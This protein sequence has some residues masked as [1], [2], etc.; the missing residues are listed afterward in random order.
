MKK[1]FFS[2][3]ACVAFAGSAFASNEVVENNMEIEDSVTS[4]DKVEF[5][6]TCL[7]NIYNSRGEFLDTVAVTNV[8]DNVSCSSQSVS[9]SAIYH[10]RQDHY[11]LLPSH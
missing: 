4:T 5:A 9:D 1:V 11:V 10:Y 2:A 8:P 7:V 3:L 6:K